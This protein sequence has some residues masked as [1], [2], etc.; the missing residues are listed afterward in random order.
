MVL[1]SVILPVYNGEQYLTRCLTI[2]YNQSFKDYELIIIDDGSTDNTKEILKHHENK[3]IIIKQFNKGISKSLNKGF[4]IARGKYVCIIAHDDWWRPNKIEIE[5][6]YICNLNVGVVYR[7]FYKV[8]GNKT[9]IIRVPEY[10]QGQL[11]RTNYINI[12][13]TMIKKDNLEKIKLIDGY[14]LDETLISCMDG[15]MWRRLSNICNFKRIPI[16]LAYYYIHDNQ[17]SK[18]YKHLQDRWRVYKRY[19][20]ISLDSFIKIYLRPILK[21]TKSKL[22]KLFNDKH[23]I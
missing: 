12:G 18:S 14:Y 13:A 10:D 15:D 7:Y 9:R 5:L 20:K 23:V 1:V 8:N 21:N 19:N 11:K 4:E 16:P 3:A 22:K 2:I 17:M 6:I